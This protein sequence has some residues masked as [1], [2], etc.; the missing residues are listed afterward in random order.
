MSLSNFIPGMSGNSKLPPGLLLYSPYAALNYLIT[1]SPEKDWNPNPGYPYY[2]GGYPAEALSPSSVQH[3]DRKN[4]APFV[5]AEHN[6]QLGDMALK[7]DVGLRYER[8]DEEIAGLQALLIGLVP[9]PG[10]KTAYSTPT[11]PAVWTEVTN[12]YSS[13]LPS[14]DLNLMVMPQLKVRADFART[15]SPPNDSLLV[16][17]TQYGGRVGSMTE[18]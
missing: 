12:S 8:T 10:D 3:V 11:A 4:Y 14:L 7:A 9:Q 13:F 15:E 18:T 16:P 6:F 17:N 5:T 2:T 1:Q